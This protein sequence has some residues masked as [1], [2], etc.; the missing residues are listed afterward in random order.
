MR[1]V[2][3]HRIKPLHSHGKLM[4][5]GGYTD[6]EGIEKITAGNRK[7]CASKLLEFNKF[8]IEHDDEDNVTYSVKLEVICTEPLGTQHDFFFAAS[9]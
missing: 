5:L 7:E 9:A 3:V 6:D 1:E 2:P 4:K 8:K